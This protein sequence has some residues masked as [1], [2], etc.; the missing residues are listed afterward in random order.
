MWLSN[1]ESSTCFSNQLTFLLML[2][3]IMKPKFT[4]T[5]KQTT[6]VSTTISLTTIPVTTQPPPKQVHDHT[7]Q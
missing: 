6:A 4:E 7:S 1:N 3:M 5:N 2:T